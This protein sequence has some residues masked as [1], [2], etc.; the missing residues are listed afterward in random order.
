MSHCSGKCYREIVAT[1]VPQATAAVISTFPARQLHFTSSP[2][3][4]VESTADSIDAREHANDLRDV[5]QETANHHDNAEQL[6][7]RTTSLQDASEQAQTTSLVT[8]VRSHQREQLLRLQQHASISQHLSTTRTSFESNYRH[9]HLSSK[10]LT[11]TSVRQA[12]APHSK[13]QTL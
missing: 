5:R 12:T 11:V 6:H 3:T 9:A 10:P 7:L 1:S 2:P 4:H 13:H 8:R